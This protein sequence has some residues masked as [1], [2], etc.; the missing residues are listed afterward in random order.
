M[1]QLERLEILLTHWI[2]HNES[3]IKSYQEWVGKL[4]ESGLREVAQKI[5]NA[6]GLISQANENFKQAEDML[7]K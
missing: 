3:H 6:A 2:E 4:K 7:K 1:E 5:E